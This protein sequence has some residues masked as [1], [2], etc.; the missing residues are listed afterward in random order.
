MTTPNPPT[1]PVVT[2]A[3]IDRM[4]ATLQ[5]WEDREPR[6]DWWS[7]QTDHAEA[8]A[9][10]TELEAALVYLAETTDDEHVVRKARQ[11]LKGKP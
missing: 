11:A 1:E 2:Q 9:V 8:L 7:Y 10:I 4:R 6:E 5:I 3:L